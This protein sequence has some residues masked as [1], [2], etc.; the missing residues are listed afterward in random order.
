MNNNSHIRKYSR[1]QPEISPQCKAF[2]GAYKK[3]GCDCAANWLILANSDPIF[4]ICEISANPVRKCFS[5]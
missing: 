2:M 1:K 5:A 3:Q 4:V